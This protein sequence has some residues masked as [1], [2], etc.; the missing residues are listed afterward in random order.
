MLGGRK[1]HVIQLPHTTGMCCIPKNYLLVTV[2][3]DSLWNP[4]ASS[5]AHCQHPVRNVSLCHGYT[6]N[7]ACGFFSYTEEM[8]LH[9]CWRNSALDQLNP[10]RATNNLTKTGSGSQRVTNAWWA[11]AFILYL[12]SLL[13]HSDTSAPFTVSSLISQFNYYNFR[14][15]SKSYSMVCLIVLVSIS[16]I[17]L[18]KC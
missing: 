17:W 11:S 10:L 14:I 9:Q 8:R 6:S 18:K 5:G 12:V 13:R 4:P 15:T 1:T 3:W 7:V 16:K 2:T